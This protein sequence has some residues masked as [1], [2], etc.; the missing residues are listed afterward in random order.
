MGAVPVAT[1][2]A[3][4]RGLLSARIEQ[5]V[6]KL[7]WWSNF[8]APVIRDPKNGELKPPV[9]PIS[10]RREFMTEGDHEM[11]IPV[12]R[13]LVG[14]VFYGD[15]I[16]TGHGEKQRWDYIKTYLNLMSF[17]VEGPAI[18]SNQDVKG[19]RLINRI[20]PQL[21]KRMVQEIDI[22]VASSFYEGFSRNITTAVSSSGLAKNKLYHPNFYTAGAG[23]ATWSGTVQ[24]HANNIGAQLA[25]LT[26][27][28]SRH[29]TVDNLENL[30]SVVQKIPLQ[31]IMIPGTGKACYIL[32]VHHNQMLQLRQDSKWRSDNNQGWVRGLTNPVFA[33][34]EGYV[35]NFLIYER[36]FS[37]FGVSESLSAGNYTLTFGATS[38][39]SAVD[40]F[41]KKVAVVFGNGAI[42]KA[43]GSNIFF[44]KQDQNIEAFEE[45]AIRQ[46]TGFARNSFYDVD[47]GEGNTPTTGVDQGSALFATYSPDA[48]T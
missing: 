11:V 24:T 34:A 33:A 32:L 15:A 17:P 46:L 9:M 18:M 5:E 43:V 6:E 48:W 4:R 14:D 26:D 40:A 21:N 2:D 3:A 10:E 39:V 42:S 19:L 1:T 36:E 25:G 29:F 45:H 12:M 30:R 22:Q 8:T 47:A 23:L 20:R 35:A 28:T 41:D 7:L 16:V 13:D 38:P 44:G 31:P 37:V 27:T